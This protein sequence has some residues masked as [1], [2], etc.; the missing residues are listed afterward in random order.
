MK[1]RISQNAREILNNP[2]AAKQLMQVVLS[3][4]YDT[5]IKLGNKKY[6]VKPAR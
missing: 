1:G 4:S 2:K 5:P 6:Y 3:R